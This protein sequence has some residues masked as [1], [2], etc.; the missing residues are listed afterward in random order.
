VERFGLPDSA[1]GQR[2]ELGGRDRGPLAVVDDV[3]PA[4]FAAVFEVVGSLPPLVAPH[5][6]CLDAVSPQ[7]SHDPS[8]EWRIR[9]LRSPRG[10]RAEAG[11]RDRHVALRARGPELEVVGGLQSLA[12]GRR[13]AQH[14]LAERHEVGHASMVGTVGHN[15]PG[16]G[17]CF[18]RDRRSLAAGRAAV[19]RQRDS[20]S[21]SSKPTE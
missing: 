6:V 17:Y 13:E 18:G 9:K 16:R 19:S 14:R 5:H 12:A 15:L 3:R 20:L 11:R 8:P 2:L 4:G 7:S 1:D 21:P 10:V